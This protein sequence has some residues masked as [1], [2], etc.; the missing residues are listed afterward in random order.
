MK[1]NLEFLEGNDGFI[2]KAEQE[3][4]AENKDLE[5]PFQYLC[6]TCGF[7]APSKSRLT[8]HLHKHA[9][10][11]SC[12][13]CPFKSHYRSKLKIHIRNKHGEEEVQKA[14]PPKIIQS[15]YSC[16]VCQHKSNFKS[17]LRNH[18]RKLHGADE[19]E[20]RKDLDQNGANTCH[21]CDYTTHYHNNLKKHI[22]KKHGENE[23]ENIMQPMKG[24]QIC[25]VCDYKT[26]FRENLR[27]HIATQHGEEELK[28]S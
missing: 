14:F 15:E 21:V 25:K 13:I 27:R 2:L 5:Y 7:E 9:E 1:E 20:L 22:V 23:L 10:P 18:I 3:S 4:Q 8:D 28:V 17:N 16:H 24:T 12:P 19:L 26:R 6:N 11:K